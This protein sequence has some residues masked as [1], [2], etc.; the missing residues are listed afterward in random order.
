MI[1]ERLI[2]IW[3]PTVIQL[4]YL[5]QFY[6]VFTRSVIVKRNFF[7]FDTLELTIPPV[8]CTH[9]HHKLSLSER[10]KNWFVVE[11]FSLK[12]F[13][14]TQIW[15]IFPRYAWPQI[16]VNEKDPKMMIILTKKKNTR[17]TIVAK[18]TNFLTRIWKLVSF[19]KSY[20]AS[21]NW[22]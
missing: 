14:L 13:F 15:M 3:F 6:D 5:L 21:L 8:K 18:G 10:M 9:I 4:F 17:L 11:K 20:L 16:L 19:R 12:W 2:T 1:G 22:S 7:F